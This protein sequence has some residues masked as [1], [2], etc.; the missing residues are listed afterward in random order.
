MQFMK[1]FLFFWIIN[2]ITIFTFEIGKETK[3]AHDTR[4][5]I[6]VII[7]MIIVSGAAAGVFSLLEIYAS[8]PEK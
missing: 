3:K 7:G 8:K 5:I 4:D 2:F 6:A 1:V